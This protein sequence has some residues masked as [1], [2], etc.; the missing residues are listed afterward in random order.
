M[1]DLLKINH[2]RFFLSLCAALCISIIVN[3][4]IAKTAY[5][6][7]PLTTL[8]VMQT[9][10]GN[11]LYQGIQRLI[12]VVLLIATAALLLTSIEFFYDT[13]HDVLMGAIIGITANSLLLP[14]RVDNAF[15]EKIFPVLQT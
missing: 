13:A 15:R 8:Y 12:L 11:A 4:Y 9:S 3:H 1:N 6:L 14:R 2:F 10:A 7:M 5:Y